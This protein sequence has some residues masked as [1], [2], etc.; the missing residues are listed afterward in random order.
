MYQSPSPRVHENIHIFASPAKN[1]G[2][3]TQYAEILKI[4]VD[5]LVS[6]EFII[7]KNRG[8]SRED[9]R[10]NEMNEEA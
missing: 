10:L 8:I 5:A 4:I 3:A 1:S 7:R 9:T 6:I 2:A